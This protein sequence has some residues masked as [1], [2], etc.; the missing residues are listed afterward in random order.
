MCGYH[1]SAIS[2][3]Q[4]KYSFA[5]QKNICAANSTFIKEAEVR[6]IFGWR[7]LDLIPVTKKMLDWVIYDISEQM[8]AEFAGSNSTIA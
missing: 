3:I 2:R 8:K 1:R 4:N 7:N 6:I 5:V